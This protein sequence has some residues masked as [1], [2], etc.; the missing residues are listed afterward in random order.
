VWETL[1]RL[2]P[3]LTAGTRLVSKSPLFGFPPLVVRRD[4][5]QAN[6]YALRNA[7]LKMASVAEGRRLLQRLNLDGF[8]EGEDGLYDGVIESVR[9]LEGAQ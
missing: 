7:L 6:F 2:E 5:S 4:I 8:T 3:G 9:I 1:S